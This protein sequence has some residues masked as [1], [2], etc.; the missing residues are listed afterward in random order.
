[1]ERQERYGK[2]EKRPLWKLQWDPFAIYSQLKLASSLTFFL[3]SFPSGHEDAPLNHNLCEC[4]CV[5]VCVCVRE[6]VCVSR[7]MCVFVRVWSFDSYWHK[8]NEE[9]RS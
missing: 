5:C 6:R 9:N 4:V 8:E 3:P 2:K 1:M 7:C